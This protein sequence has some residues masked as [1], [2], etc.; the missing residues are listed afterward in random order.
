[1]LTT[2]SLTQR[3][4]PSVHRCLCLHLDRSWVSGVWSA[5]PL[6]P[7]KTAS[8]K[9]T[10]LSLSSWRSLVRGAATAAAGH[11]PAPSLS[12]RAE[13]ARSLADK[14]RFYD[15]VRV[16][17]VPNVS[18]SRGSWDTSSTSRSHK[19]L[20]RRQQAPSLH[21]CAARLQGYQ[22]LLGTRPVRTPAKHPLVLPTYPLALAVAAEWEWL[23]RQ[24][25]AATC[26]DPST[27]MQFVAWSF[28]VCLRP[29]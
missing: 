10:E 13:L 29:N 18:T 26:S 9:F 21:V 17:S 23:V 4:A 16:S 24:L 5:L 2:L 12:Q 11:E 20:Q 15:T 25:F 6:T 7:H 3:I 22:V 28:Q 27:P 1:M 14:R 19:Q 8:S